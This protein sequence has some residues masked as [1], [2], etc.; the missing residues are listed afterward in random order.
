M[1]TSGNER[2]DN[3][4]KQDSNRRTVLRHTGLD[5]NR[6]FPALLGL[7][8]FRRITSICRQAFA[9]GRCAVHPVNRANRRSAARHPRQSYGIRSCQKPVRGGT[10]VFEVAAI[11]S[12]YAAFRTVPLSGNLYASP[13]PGSYVSRV[14]VGDPPTVKPIASPQSVNSDKW[15]ATDV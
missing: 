11:A 7:I 10:H 12:A 3:R 13:C 5:T 14:P 1:D 4:S 9:V 8:V 6:A 15:P 2:D